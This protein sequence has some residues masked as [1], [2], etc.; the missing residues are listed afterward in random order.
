MTSKII[1]EFIT[2]KQW[3]FKQIGLTDDDIQAL[4]AMHAY[5]AELTPWVQLNY[6]Y[7]EKLLKN[8]N[9]SAACDIF[10]V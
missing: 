6:E 10:C 2:D 9:Y 7:G 4:L 8:S 1:Y 5:I 3:M